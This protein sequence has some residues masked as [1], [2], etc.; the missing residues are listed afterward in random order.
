MGIVNQG[1][2]NMHDDEGV[3][4]RHGIAEK[5]AAVGHLPSI[6]ERLD[7]KAAEA[8]QRHCRVKAIRRYKEGLDHLQR[9]KKTTRQWSIDED[10]I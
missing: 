5:Q 3:C 2:R 7:E 6:A 4:S 10:R 1:P 9:S 8:G